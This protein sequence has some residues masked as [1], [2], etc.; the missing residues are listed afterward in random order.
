MQSQRQAVRSNSDASV[1][2]EIYSS[3]CKGLCSSFPAAVIKEK[4]LRWSRAVP[5]ILIPSKDE[6][7][8]SGCDLWWNESEIAQFRQEA[9][10]ELCR[11]SRI[12]SI[13]KREAKNILYQSSIVA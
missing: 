13:S 10:E 12:F 4:S 1:N 8:R 11:V 7:K 3:S 2:Y 9:Y 5:T 6:F